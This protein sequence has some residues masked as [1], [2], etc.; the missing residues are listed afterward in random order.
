MTKKI[1]DH[2]NSNLPTENEP[3]QES[4]ALYVHRVIQVDKGQD[5]I[6]V[7]KFLLNR[8][9]NVSRN[10]IQ[11]GIDAG[12]VLV[13][14]KVVKCNYRIKPGDIISIVL[15]EEPVNHFLVAENI[16]LN[17]VYEDA[18][19]ALVNKPAGMVVHP[20]VGNYTG[21]LVN[22][23]LYHF[24]QQSDSKQL[25]VEI[26]EK[27]SPESFT[28]EVRPY[29]VHRID[30]NTSGILVV[31]KNQT[32][33]E[34]LGKQFFYHSIQRKYLA[35]IWG[36]PKADEGT[37]TGNIGRNPND[38]QKFYVTDN[39]EEGK[40]AVTHYKVIERMGYVSLIECQLETG[41]THQIRVHMSN[42]GHP[43]FSDETYGGNK[44]MKGTIYAKYKQ[45]VE[46]CFAMC[47]RQALHAQSLG[48]I[49]P[50]T[51]KEI[52][53]EVPMPDDMKNVIEKWRNF[54]KAMND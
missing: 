12:N 39:P 3:Q 48:F 15:A 41:R 8:L 11:I 13:N 29:L 26:I 36:E 18:E 49:H 50:T 14:K 25:A 10:K 24:L 46:N 1:P 31:A 28:Q 27:R 42:I 2:I 45:F 21:T 6:R 51:Q 4:E 19:I 54:V 22:G 52:Y 43:I 23:L 40:H 37:I 53:H 47:P 34:F 7:D 17:I 44:I 33:L 9:E 20:G 32:A 16:P 35:L 30:K 38:R 5:Y